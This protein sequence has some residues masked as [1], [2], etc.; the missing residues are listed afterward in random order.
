M[1]LSAWVFTIFFLL[2]NAI[3]FAET[4][5][6]SPNGTTDPSHNQVEVSADG[7]LEWYEEQGLYVARDKAQAIRGDLTVTADLLTAHKR[8]A[9][10]A[11]KKGAT[12]SDTGDLDKLT[13]EG[14]VVI[15]KGKATITGDKAVNDVDKHVIL[16]TGNDLRYETDKQVVT[17]R[18]SLEYWD[19]KKIAVARGHAIAVQGD[20][21]ISGDILTAEFR[22][23]P[24]GSSQLYKMTAVGNVT[25]LT[26]T[27]IVRG[28]KG[29]Y[30]AVRDTAIITG[31]VRITRPDGTE[32]TGD[33]AE[34]DFAANQSRLLNQ[35]SGRVRA[36]LPS[37]GSTNKPFKTQGGTLP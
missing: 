19:D 26:K 5:D 29:V 9:A 10:P 18:E 1:R 6:V 15:V 35:G 22:D 30:D 17:A 23:Q 20:R 11:G 4:G 33:V 3:A 12:S 34:A 37:K 36:L 7:S 32:L 14:H 31:H 16:V 24:N 28:D 27:D 21:H 25:V 13:A 2:G 8:E